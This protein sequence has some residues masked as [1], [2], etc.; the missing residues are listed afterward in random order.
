MSVPLRSEIFDDVYFCTENGL[1]ETQHVFLAG[2]GLPGLW[3]GV[4]HFTVFETGFGTGLNFLALWS[5][6]EETASSGQSLD[7]VSFERYPLGPET[8]R[9]ALSDW[10]EE[11]GPER[12]EIFLK[13]GGRNFEALRPNGGIVRLRVIEGD[14]NETLPVF[15]PERPVDAWFLDGFSPA[16]NPQMWG[17]LLYENMARLSRPGTRCA[18]FTA[19]GAVRRGLTQVGFQVEKSPGFGKKRHMVRGIFHGPLSVL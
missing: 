8:I 5:L 13:E 15:Q 12:L 18:T 1:A 14:I 3:D 7:F 2:N 9:T 16:K 10:A 17:D 11:L 6:F 19:A 4:E